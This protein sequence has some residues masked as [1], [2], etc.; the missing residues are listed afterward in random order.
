MNGAT[1]SPLIS[2]MLF[3]TAGINLLLTFMMAA[4]YRPR[5]V[6][7]WFGILTAAAAGWAFAINGFL[8]STDTGAATLWAR[9]YYVAGALIA[10]AL[11]EFSLHYPRVIRLRHGV[12]ILIGAAF[13]A[14]MATPL[15]DGG[16]IDHVTMT[17]TLSNVVALNMPFYY[18]YIAYYVVAVGLAAWLFISGVIDTRRRHSRRLSRILTFFGVG[19]A[20]SLIGGMW[21]NLLLPLFGDYGYIWAGPPCAI[22]FALAA[23]VAI[24]Q[25]GILD[26][27]QALART[28]VYIAVAA[29]LI[30]IYSV[31]VFG[32]LQLFLPNG[33]NREVQMVV[34]TGVAV[35]LALL[36]QPLREFF[37]RIAGHV[38]Y[39]GSYAI[40]E[41]LD[42][43]R[44]VTSN[45]VKTAT[46]A[47]K[48]LDTLESLLHAERIGL[49][50]YSDH[51][52]VYHAAGKSLTDYQRLLWDELTTLITPV[53]PRM[54]DEQVIDRLAQPRI[55]HVFNSAHLQM[56]VQLSVRHQP[57][58]LLLLGAKRSGRHYD[59]KD[60]R[61]LGA[62]ANEL[63][64]ALQNS[65][66]FQEIQVF[67][68]TLQQR[69]GDATK[70]LRASNRQ[71]QKL[72]EA[73]DEFVSMASHQL[74]TPL[75][76]VKGYIDMVLQ[77]DAGK[78]TPM[79]HQLL[80]EAFTSSE[81][82]VHLINDFLNV[83]RL[84]TGKFMLDRRPIDLAKVVGQEVDA[85][86]TTAG[87]REL[88][89]QYHPPSR[90]PVLYLDEGKLR[91]V[92]MNFIDNAIYYSREHST[93]KIRLKVELGDVVFEVHDKGIGVP[94]AEQAHLFTK[95]FRA[96]N[97]RKQ[98]P[99]GTGVG[100]Y[101]AKRVITD[102]GGSMIF[103]S[104]EGEGSVFGFRL[105]VKRLSTAPASD[106]DDL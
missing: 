92:V 35:V 103:S 16:L 70:E 4:A 62:V 81:R 24:T 37:D 83:S 5:A 28:I 82:M 75:T 91:Q 89:L 76:S 7:V 85:L 99:D 71:L 56:V 27:Q 86:R 78:I 57:V 18:T 21:F 79:Q 104:V 90:M 65:L 23:L 52:Q 105:P 29:A 84:Q 11:L 31:L 22:V 96:A 97:A 51:P 64:V 50:V 44:D 2:L 98:R 9:I 40:D 77:G 19:I 45:E 42:Q 47:T 25:R 67:N 10:Y 14:L 3:I 72:D 66:R 59:A 15:I 17:P 80:S 33:S 101:L 93:I 36:V 46:L 102:H 26:L 73:K 48:T 8:T 61:L 43:I 6:H 54:I 30:G 95:F 12:H 13:A 41:A 53:M 39:R 1:L 34:Q 49:Y 100:I 88:Q 32:V 63:S 38:F 74:R 106:P 87:S 60:A 55:E 58:G 94:K 69:I 68:T 20:A